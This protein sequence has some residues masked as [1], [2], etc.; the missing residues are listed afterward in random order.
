MHQILFF[1]YILCLSTLY[2]FSCS[3]SQYCTKYSAEYCQNSSLWRGNG[4]LQ[5]RLFRVKVMK[6]KYCTCTVYCTHIIKTPLSVSSGSL[7]CLLCPPTSW[8]VSWYVF[9][10]CSFCTNS[11]PFLSQN[12]SFL[13]LC[14]TDS[15]FHV[16]NLCLR[17][18][19]FSF[20][21]RLS[22]LLYL[23]VSVNNTNIF[24]H[25][26]DLNQCTEKKSTLFHCCIQYHSSQLHFVRNTILKK[27]SKQ[28][29]KPYDST[30]FK[31]TAYWR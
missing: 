2:S 29:V 3:C 30:V 18:M 12:C 31:H 11:W 10:I 22:L 7:C 13:I 21:D 15:Y 1:N 24:Y 19:N 27:H 28:I 16:T 6:P 23:T 9:L 17:V 25:H 4:Y 5:G 26:M 20:T 14:N 8:Q